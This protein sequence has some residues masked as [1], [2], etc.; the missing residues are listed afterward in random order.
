MKS[1]SGFPDLQKASTL[2]ALPSSVPNPAQAVPLRM[3]GLSY[4]PNWG[5]PHVHGDEPRENPAE[6]AAAERDTALLELNELRRLIERAETSCNLALTSPY[7]RGW[8]TKA[9]PEELEDIK[10]TRKTLNQFREAWIPTLS[11]F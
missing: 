6:K 5:N 9:S 3:N 7:Y 2:A 11:T 1:Y 8:S 4:T 10:R